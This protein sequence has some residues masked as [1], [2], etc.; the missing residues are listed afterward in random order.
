MKQVSIVMPIY[1]GEQYLR[2]SIESIRNQTFQDWELL[3]VNDCS[4]D[5]SLWIMEEYAKMDERICIYSNPKN[6]NLPNTLNVGFREASGK[7]L[8]W[9]SDDNLYMPDAIET[10]Y[11]ALESRSDVGLVYCD[12]YYIDESGRVT[13]QISTGEEQLYFND[14]VGACFMYRAEVLKTVGEYDPD[15]FLVED[16]DYWLRLSRQYRICHLPEIHYY[17]RRHTHSLTG[18][19]AWEINRQLFRLRLKYMDFLLERSSEKVR[20]MLFMDMWF[21]SRETA[22]LFRQ[23][24]FG[25]K[26]LPEGIQWIERSAGMDSEKKIILYGAGEFGEKALRFF[27]TDKVAFFVDSNEEKVGSLIKGKRVLSRKEL[28]NIYQDYNVVIST[29]ARKTAV[30]AEV[31]DAMGINTYTTYLEQAYCLKKPEEKNCDW[32]KGFQKASEW[33]EKHTVSGKG[34]INN[35]ELNLAYPEVT[36]YF[37]PSLLK[38]GFRD[39]ALSYGKWLCSIQNED[40]SW[41]DTEGKSP[42][43]FDTAQILKGLLAV[44]NMLPEAEECI[45]K[46]CRWILGQ[47][48]EEGKLFTPSTEAWGSCQCSDLIHLYCLSPLM[49]AGYEKE[50][51]HIANYYLENRMDEIMEFGL[52]SHFYGYVMEA[53]WDIG[54]KELADKGMKRIAAIQRENG[55]VPAYRDVNWVCSTGLMQFAL[56]WYKLGDLEHG[57]R[58]FYYSMS[59]QNESGGWFGSYP[60]SES[61][62]GTDRKEYPDYFSNQEISWAVKYF[63]DALYYKCKGEFEVQA[64]YFPKY[65]GKEDGRYRLILDKVSELGDGAKVLDAGCGKGRYLINLMED[66]PKVKLSGSDISEKAT[67][68]IPS[69]IEIKMGSLTY[70]PYENE[71][72]EMVYAIE[73]LEHAIAQEN[74]VKELLRVTC[75]NGIVIIIDKNESARGLLEMDSWEKWFEDSF[76]E[77]IAGKMGCG[78]EIVRNIPY[79]DGVADGLFNGWILK[80]KRRMTPNG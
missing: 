73:S 19:R 57:N 22:D 52:L 46:G 70:L 33:I 55:M 50:A 42:Y 79:E 10:M 69:S 72:F 14:C 6:L 34:I 21:Q 58:A 78:L 18:T 20:E 5:R 16:Y 2:E 24:F 27:G 75:E 45:R 56:V 47:A 43:I 8:T 53:L 15:M 62:K 51:R 63:L 28:K 49:D 9:T 76:F 44:R 77:D 36:G 12:M 48:N 17:Y 29:D 71:S 66:A 13:G 26:I 3:L 25:T 80:K 4:T 37:I 68:N 32:H 67:G 23:K 54:Q 1:N 31:L 11:Y 65:I 39:L 74:A 41:N 64:S 60:T 61:P 7:Y 59:L 30:I 35:T 38:W 40:G